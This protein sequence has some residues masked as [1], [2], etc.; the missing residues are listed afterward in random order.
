MVE[1]VIA[2]HSEHYGLVFCTATET[3]TVEE[4]IT[5]LA[6]P[7][8]VCY[9]IREI[10]EVDYPED[11]GY[12]RMLNILIEKDKYGTAYVEFDFFWDDKN[13]LEWLE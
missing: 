4:F 11:S 12:D 5:H 8:E 13:T 3:W 9:E 1:R 7:H 2:V 6:D 10:W